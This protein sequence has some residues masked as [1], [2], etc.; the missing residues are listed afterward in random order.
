LTRA[1]KP[2]QVLA[3]QG[4][5]DEGNRTPPISASKTPISENPHEKRAESGALESQNTPVDP[6]LALIQNRWPKLPEHIKAAVM[7]LIQSSQAQ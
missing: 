6:D 2:A 3:G 5:G 1:R 7:A 4:D